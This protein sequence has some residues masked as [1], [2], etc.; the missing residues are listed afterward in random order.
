[1]SFAM[2]TIAALQQATATA[3]EYFEN[4]NPN[5]FMFNASF[6]VFPDF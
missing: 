5:G 4:K 2:R 3:H 1:M 6:F